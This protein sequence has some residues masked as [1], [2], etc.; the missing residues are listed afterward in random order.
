MLLRHFITFALIIETASVIAG[1]EIYI[2]YIANADKPCMFIAKTVGKFH[3]TGEQLHRLG[4]VVVLELLKSLV[5]AC[6]RLRLR[7]DCM[8]LYI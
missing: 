4:E 5:H 7:L 1:I 6:R 8:Y 3:A 2:A